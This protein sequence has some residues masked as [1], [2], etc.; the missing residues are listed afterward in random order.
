MC[1]RLPACLHHERHHRRPSE[2]R[3]ARDSEA[4]PEEQGGVQCCPAGDMQLHVVCRQGMV[5]SLFALLD[6]MGL[7]AAFVS[8]ALPL[9]MLQ[10]ISLVGR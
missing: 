5:K 1:R 7:A 2:D 3:Y 10:R 4:S 6:L 8:C 9:P